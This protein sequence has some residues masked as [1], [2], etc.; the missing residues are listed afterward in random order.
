M[1][2][3]TSF[4]ALGACA[5]GLLAAVL[6]LLGGNVR[7]LDPERPTATALVVKDDSIVFVGADADA[8][9]EAGPGATR[10]DLRGRLVLPG[11]ID[12]HGHLSSLGALEMGA[13]DLREAKSFDEVV[14]AV[15][16]E[17]KKRKKGEWITGGRWDHESWPGR[18]LPTHERISEAAP[19]NPVLLS[20]VDGHMALA[21]AAALAAAGIGPETQNPPGGAILRAADG[22]TPSGLLVDN[23][24]DLVYA[25]V[26]GGGRG[27]LEEMLLAAEK[28]CFSVGLTSVHDAGV[29][30][31]EAEAVVRLSKEGSLRLGV[32]A[33]IAAS[34]SGFDY[35]EKHAP[36]RGLGKSKNVSVACM[37][38]VADG[39]MGSR[40]AWLLAPYADRPADEKGLPYVGL[41]VTS[42]PALASIVARCAAR[43]WQ[44][45]THAIGDRANR[46]ILDAYERAYLGSPDAKISG[47]ADAAGRARLK[48]A[49][50]RVEHAQLL[51][52]E[53]LP[54]FASLGVIASMQPSHATSDM[55]WA[56]SRVGKARLPG[57][58]AWKTLLRSGA[59]LAFGSDFPVEA[60]DPL[61]GIHA[62]VTRQ[63]AEG[64]PAGGWRPEER[65]TREEAIAAFTRGAA[66]AA[67]EEDR[68]GLLRKGMRAD[69]VVL[70]RDILTCDPALIRTAQVD[71]TICGG[72]VVFARP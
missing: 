40:G 32:H 28:K 27:S 7:T 3:L 8:L 53:D 17:V 69:I 14:A 46:E 42:P 13:L 34:P 68:K 63:D 19:E 11:F 52:P 23:A 58:Y 51:S 30:P 57:A 26:T 43:G 37:K 70:S 20:R 65:L 1:L 56:E 16:D 50:L 45:A 15:R 33:M 38:V 21:N 36:A 66:Y 10:I 60:P 9:A 44:V 64:L 59:A 48:A 2:T 22:R 24:L 39:A 67:F 47:D 4:A 35:V 61:Q 18:A 29:E 12:A 71:M 62:A 6:V 5:P 55:R 25:K 49:R 31:R 72:L 54:R 41:P